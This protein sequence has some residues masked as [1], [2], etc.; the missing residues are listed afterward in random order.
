MGKK[1][2]KKLKKGGEKGHGGAID[3]GVRAWIRVKFDFNIK[4]LLLLYI[5]SEFQQI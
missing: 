2:F 1:K 4:R 5:L 3:I